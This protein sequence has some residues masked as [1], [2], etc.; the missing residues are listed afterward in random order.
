MSLR[1]TFTAA[2][3]LFTFALSA[4]LYIHYF[5][6]RQPTFFILGYEKQHEIKAHKSLVFHTSGQPLKGIHSKTSEVTGFSREL[7]CTIAPESRFDCARDRLV[8][9]RECEERGC[10]Y[11][12]LPGSAGPPW[13]FYPSFYPG[14]R[15]GPFTPTTHGQAATLT[16]TAPSYL[17]R[18]ISVLELEVTQASAACLHIT[19][20]TKHIFSHFQITLKRLVEVDLVEIPADL[21]LQKMLQNLS[22]FLFTSKSLETE[23][24]ILLLLFLAQ[25]HFILL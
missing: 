2:P 13:C 5:Y 20:S 12:P 22:A 11:A 17:P 4:C 7:K 3:L 14:Y 15:M 21:R 25:I 18:D 16:R 1:C 24:K 6:T 19:V 23:G 10:C 9:R 8:S